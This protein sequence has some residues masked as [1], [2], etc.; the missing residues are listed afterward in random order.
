MW[1]IEYKSSSNMKGLVMNG[2]TKGR[3]MYMFIHESVYGI[4]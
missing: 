1:Y 3:I 2:A 4:E